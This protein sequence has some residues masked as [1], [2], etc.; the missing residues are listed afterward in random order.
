MGKKRILKG[1]AAVLIVAAVAFAGVCL[2]WY[3]FRYLP[4][5]R[6]TERMQ[7]E[8]NPE[9]PRY[10]AESGDYRFRIKMPAFLSFESGFLYVGPAEELAGFVME[11]D[12]TLTERN[13][14]HVDMFIWPKILSGAAYGV[15]LYGE[16]FS[17][18]VIVDRDGEFLEGVSG[19]DE[20]ELREL[21]AEHRDE[22]RDIMA[23]ARDFWGDDFP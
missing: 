14:P 12:G 13:V 2:F 20:A 23:A 16:D 21:C 9:M 19:R 10:C 18:Q 4:Y 5:H 11:D 3:G 7:P 1:I 17:E 6:L 8:G 22:I 15:T